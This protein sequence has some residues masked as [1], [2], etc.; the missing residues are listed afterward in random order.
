[1]KKTIFE[2]LNIPERER[3]GIT[4]LLFLITASLCFLSFRDSI[5][6]TKK[7]PITDHEKEMI[8]WLNTQEEIEIQKRKSK[9]FYR[10][11]SFEKSQHKNSRIKTPFFF[12]PNTATFS[13]L[14]ALG[15]SK[16]AA[17]SL[18]AYRN[19]GGQFR[20]AEDLKKVR[21][22]TDSQFVS[23]KQ[24]VQL[25]SEETH[26]AESG[27]KDMVN[28]KRRIELNTA[29]TT[30]LIQ[31]PGIG[32]KLAHR[33]VSYRNRLGG[34]YSVEQLKEVYGLRP[35]V[36]EK[37][38][39]D[40]VLDSPIKTININTCTLQDLL[41]HPYLKPL[42]A[43]GIINYREKH[44][45]FTSVEGLRKTDLVDEELYTKIAPYFSVQ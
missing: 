7:S 20:F 30:T 27:T 24:F 43:R 36:F 45:S 1:M 12:N 34:F 32:S 16:H 6:L 8:A 44:G 9:S 17:A 35:E 37:I 26:Q 2:F 41:N 33:I 21:G 31:L 28:S 39:S 5:V 38:S 42:Q 4:A 22:L 18:I 23:L 19:K 11:S 3:K 15:M 40:F 13:E 10:N 14:T 25:P 29:D